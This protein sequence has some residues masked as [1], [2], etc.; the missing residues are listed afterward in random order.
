MHATKSA[1]HPIPMQIEPIVLTMSHAPIALILTEP[2][3]RG[4][5][6]PTIRDLGKQSWLIVMGSSGAHGFCER[7]ARRGCIG[8]GL[9]FAG[10]L[11]RFARPPKMRLPL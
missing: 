9:S 6:L 2:V 3:P 10:V 11:P 5:I 8:E 1:M 4:E 7:L